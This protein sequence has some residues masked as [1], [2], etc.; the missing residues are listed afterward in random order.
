[1]KKLPLK[2]CIKQNLSEEVCK[3]FHQYSATDS[4]FIE[5]SYIYMTF[6]SE[7]EESDLSDTKLDYIEITLEDF[8]KFVLNK[9]SKSDKHVYLTKILKKLNIK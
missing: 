9:H 5:G 3:W 1:M 8:N 4:A 6:D 7:T 2:W